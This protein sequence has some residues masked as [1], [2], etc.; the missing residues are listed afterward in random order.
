MKVRN[1]ILLLV[2]ALCCTLA[3]AKD[4]KRPASYNYTRATELYGQDNY[5]EATEYL[6][7]ELADNPKNGYAHLLLGIIAYDTD[8]YGE[9]LTYVNDALKY[10]NK[11]DNE[12]VDGEREDDAETPETSRDNR[13]AR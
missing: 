13:D 9:G 1:I 4:I 3:Q 5:A 2:V 7:K 8:Q 6:N 11:K 10:L 12:I